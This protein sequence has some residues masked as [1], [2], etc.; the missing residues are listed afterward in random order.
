ME[1]S[2]FTPGCLEKVKNF[3]SKENTHS[4][5][6]LIGKDEAAL[7]IKEAAMQAFEESSG[8]ESDG[9]DMQLDYED[10]GKASVPNC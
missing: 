1:K 8:E 9:G 2:P 6:V 7:C 3:V 5:L 10:G 4:T